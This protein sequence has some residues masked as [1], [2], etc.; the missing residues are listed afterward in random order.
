[1]DVVDFHRRNGDVLKY[2]PPLLI[3]KKKGISAA[4]LPPPWKGLTLEQT[5]YEKYGDDLGLSETQRKISEDATQ[6]YAKQCVPLIIH[7]PPGTGKTWL[8]V[9]RML[10]TTHV[11]SNLPGFI[12]TLN[13]TLARAHLMD[14]EEQ[15]SDGV[16]MREWNYEQRVK[17][18][19]DRIRVEGLQEILIDLTSENEEVDVLTSKDLAAQWKIACDAVMNNREVVNAGNLHVHYN[20]AVFDYR[21]LMFNQF[22]PQLNSCEEWRAN[23]EERAK[24]SL[25]QTQD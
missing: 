4:A 10:G 18:I 9:E 8:A 17:F 6:I 16:V 14:L 19:N 24:E 11:V 3:E 22:G 25:W 23:A 1:M 12:V 15:H 21:N 20:R 7:G 2:I 13:A 5:T